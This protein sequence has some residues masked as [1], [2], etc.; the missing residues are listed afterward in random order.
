VIAAL[1]GLLIPQ[2]QNAELKKLLQDVTP[3]FNAHLAHAQ[4]VQ[5]MFAK[6]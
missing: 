3:A 6:K 1:T 4:M 2:S 5:K